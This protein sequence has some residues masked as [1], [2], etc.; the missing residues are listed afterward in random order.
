[1]AFTPDEKQMIKESLSLY[2]QYAGQQV[3]PEQLQQIGEAAQAI[4]TKLD[5]AL[6]GD[7]ESLMPAGISEEWFE[8]VCAS[9]AKLTPAGCED[10]VTTKFPGKCDPILKFEMKKIQANL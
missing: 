10:P 2:L 1:M 3:A 6:S 8:N 9:C 7:G 5:T 4:V